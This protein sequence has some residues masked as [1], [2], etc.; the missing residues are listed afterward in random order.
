MKRVGA[1]VAL[2]L[3]E[4]VTMS[5]LLY[6]SETWTLNKME[7]NL[8][9]RAEIY[10]IK[11]VL[12]LPKTTPTAGIV[13]STGILFT[14]VRIEMKQLIFLQKVLKKDENHWT[15]VTLMALKELNHGWAKQ[16]DEVL[17][18]WA[19]EEDWGVIQAKTLRQWKSEVKESAEKMNREKVREECEMKSRGEKKSRFFRSV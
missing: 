1:K 6:N 7:K 2:D 12:G 4:A 9:N 16:I 19:L 5:T 13:F 14:S 15:R 18:N 17:H 11:K 8:M 3:H 10:A